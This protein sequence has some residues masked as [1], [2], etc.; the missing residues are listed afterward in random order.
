[1]Q[2]LNVKIDFHDHSCSQPMTA[3]WGLVWKIV[4]HGYLCRRR[5]GGGMDISV[6]NSLSWLFVPLTETAAEWGLV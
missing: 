4:F 6:K 2:I 1:M 3:E 5:N